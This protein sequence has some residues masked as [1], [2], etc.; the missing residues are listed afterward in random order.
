MLLFPN[1]YDVIYNEHIHDSYYNGPLARCVSLRV[2]HAPGMLGTFSPPPR[3]SEPDMHHDTCVTHVSWWMPGSLTTSL[4]WSQWWGKRHTRGMHNP[5]FY[6]SGKRPIAASITAG[7][8]HRYYTLH[9]NMKCYH[10][11]PDKKSDDFN[12]W[13]QFYALLKDCV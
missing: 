10:I 2:V 4:I 1:W 13:T 5:Q 7:H 3:V 12:I 11:W 6:V 9:S 8:S